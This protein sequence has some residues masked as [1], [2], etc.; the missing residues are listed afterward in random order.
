MTN[1]RCYRWIGRFIPQISEYVNSLT[2]KLS[3]TWHAD[4]VFVKMKGGETVRGGMDRKKM[5]GMAYLWNIMDRKTR[6]LLASRLSEK[7]DSVG[8]IGAFNRA[9]NVA[10]GSEPEKVMTDALAAYSDYYQASLR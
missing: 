3:D 6:F 5:D 9:I 10:H 4:E 1:R 2:P 7:R 8:A